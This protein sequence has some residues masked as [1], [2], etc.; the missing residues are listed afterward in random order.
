MKAQILDAARV[1][2]R[3][4]RRASELRGEHLAAA[5]AC[6]EEEF[7]QAFPAVDGFQRELA[8]LLF[9][10]AR[11]A[12][13]RAVADMAPGVAQLIRAFLT[14]LDYNLAHPSLQE[15][16]HVIQFEPAGYEMLQRMEGSVMLLAQ[17]DLAADGGSS[18][19]ARARLLTSLVVVVVRAEYKAGRALPELREALFDY[20]RAS[21]PAARVG[22]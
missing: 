13:I 16:A 8:V 11:D 17:A 9:T 3:S 15:I 7:D 21:V 19:A 6:T 12:V 18:C 5:G 14:Y 4:N 1:L 2:I 22:D 20:C 10:D